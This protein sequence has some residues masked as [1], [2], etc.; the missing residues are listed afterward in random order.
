MSD[1]ALALIREAKATKSTVL[2]LGMCGLTELPKELF[3]LVW[4]EE[5]TLS[6]E[7]WDFNKEE[8]I[9]SNNFHAPNTLDKLPE[10]FKA[11]Q[12]LKIL[13]CNGT[14]DNKWSITDISSLQYCTQL[15]ML[16]LWHNQVT[17]ISSLQYCTQLETLDLSSNQVTDI[18]PLQYCTQLKVLD[19]SD[20]QIISIQALLPLI[21]KGMAISIKES[22]Y[23]YKSNIILKGN[24]VKEPPVE[25][26]QQGNA[27]IINY[28]EEK[29]R[30]GSAYLY[31]AKMLIVG[32]GGVGKTSLARKIINRTW[33]LPKEEDTTKGIDIHQ[34]KYPY[35]DTDFTINIWDFGGQE[36]YSATHQFFLTKRSLYVLVDD[37]RRSDKAIHDH[38]FRYWLQTIELFGDNSPL[39][40]VQNEKGG[41]SKDID[42]QQMQGRFGFIKEK[43]TTNLLT[44]EGVDVIENDIKHFIEKLPHVGESLPKHWIKIRKALEEKEKTKAY[45]SLEEYYDICSKHDITDPKKALLLSGYLHDLGVFLHFQEAPLLKKTVILQNEWATDAVYRV[46]DNEKIK[47][48]Y[49]HFT[50]SDAC[51]LWTEDHYRNMHDE[52]LSLMTQF[53]L[54][55]QLEDEKEAYLIPQLLPESRPKDFSWNNTDNLQLRFQY[56]FLPKGLLSRLMVRMHRYL[57][58]RNKAWKNGVVLEKNNTQAFVAEDYLGREISIRIKGEQAKELMTILS[59]AFEVLHDSYGGIKVDKKVPCICTT[60]TQLDEPHFYD[61]KDLE[62]RFYRKK[63]TIECVKDP[64]E[65]VDV[66]ELI[67]P[68]IAQLLKKEKESNKEDENSLPPP[69]TPSTPPTPQWYKQ[70]WF[71]YLLASV[72]AGLFGAFATKHFFAWHFLSGFYIVFSIVA[73]ILFSKWNPERRYFRMAV[74]SLITAVALVAI[75][76]GGSLE[77]EQQKEASTFKLVLEWLSAYDW[78]IALCLLPLSAFLFYLDYK[79]DSKN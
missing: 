52:L 1:Y 12:Q 57:K 72:G 11:L 63:M 47:N 26:I 40:I 60:C 13:R 69:P 28:F 32:E 79:K 35:K 14:R 44:C 51:A 9:E 71:N 8:W 5:L 66:K 68:H 64:F 42:F 61:Y 21:Q 34:L 53:E 7:Y 77:W 4:L 56:H 75:N 22:R 39:L 70:W 25:I 18:S 59:E 49:G 17:D 33:E 45:I 78:V 58:D 48:N 10:A 23:F 55:Y 20:N 62:V 43:Y 3:E 15:K 19:L 50:R 54:C 6:N 36:I 41:R 74:H 31:E 76:L 16:K 67:N 65:T 37:T 38:T 24:P 27:A 30:Q 73:F 2:D 29:E 46:L